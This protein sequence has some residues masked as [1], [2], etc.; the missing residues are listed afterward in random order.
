M[1][2]ETTNES[3]K[4]REVKEV[5]TEFMI[6]RVLLC[7]NSESSELSILCNVLMF[8]FQGLTHSSMVFNAF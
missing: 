6:S 5:D 1:N 3:N 4:V 8:K 2:K 7:F